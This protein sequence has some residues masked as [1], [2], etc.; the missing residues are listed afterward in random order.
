MKDVTSRAG[1]RMFVFE[2]AKEIADYTDKDTF[3]AGRSSFV[4][5]NIDSWEELQE[6]Q[7]KAWDHG[8]D[9]LTAAVERLRK[10]SIP[11]LKD[12]RRKTTFSMD[13]GDEV[14]PEKMMQG[15]AYWRQATREDHEGPTE[16]TVITDTTTECGK[17]SDD[18]LWRG[19][20]AIALAIVLEEKGYK[21]E[22]WVANGSNLFARKSTAVM[23]ACCLKRPQDPLDISTLVNTVSG[24]FYRTA[25]FTLLNTICRKC[26]EEMSMGY[27]YCREPQPADLDELSMDDLRIYCSGVFSF[28]GA[29]DCI[30][31]EL[32]KFHKKGDT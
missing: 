21:V 23:T 11:D 1:S 10:E 4:G 5:A 25:T 30:K 27:G 19:A 29:L 6:M 31:A 32:N 20:V 2:S 8:I 24:W 13:E 26:N 28:S 3:K 17:D 7:T 15:E 18:I 16:V 12:H 14:D 22:L 9:V